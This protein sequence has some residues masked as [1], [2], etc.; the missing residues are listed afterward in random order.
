MRSDQLSDSELDV[1]MERVR[2]ELNYAGAAAASAGG[3]IHVSTMGDAHGLGVASPAG[4]LSGFGGNGRW[5]FNLAHRINLRF[6][7]VPIVGTFLRYFH[8][9]ARLP[10]AV[11]ATREAQQQLLARLVVLTDAV[12]RVDRALVERT[13]EVQVERNAQ[14]QAERIAQMQVELIAQIQVDRIAQIQQVTDEVRKQVG[15]LTAVIEARLASISS[16]ADMRGQLGALSAKFDSVDQRLAVLL[17][18]NSASKVAPRSDRVGLASEI[19][20]APELEN[21]MPADQAELDS[22]YVAFEDRFRGTR[23]DIKGRLAVHLGRVLDLGEDIRKLPVV[24]IGC[25]RGAWIEL[26]SEAGVPA[27]GV[28]TNGVMVNECIKR[29]FSVTHRDALVHLRNM[30]EGTASVI[31]GFHVIEH[32]PHDVVLHI[33]REALRVLVPGGL[34]IF[35]TPNPE[36]LITAAHRFFTDPTHRSPIPPDLASFLLRATGYRDVEIVRLHENHDSARD[37]IGSPVLRQLLYG[38]QDFAVVGRK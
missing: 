25:G 37:E 6:G 33:L 31:T 5:Y 17:R 12:N 24:D 4:P 10:L 18:S 27:L 38:P 8:H 28:D 32:L 16:L 36:N 23:E 9:A 14:I 35:E 20:D 3:V 21:V 2:Q 13:A 26:L 1:L 34:V 22:L 15:A 29:G 11:A 30:E 7:H 19:A